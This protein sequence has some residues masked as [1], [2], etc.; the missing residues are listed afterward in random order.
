MSFPDSVLPPLAPDALSLTATALGE[1]PVGPSYSPAWF[2]SALDERKPTTFDGLVK[3][4]GGSSSSTLALAASLYKDAP[5]TAATVEGTLTLTEPTGLLG[6]LHVKGDLN[7]QASLVV[8]GTLTVDGVLT[9]GPETKLVVLGQ[10]RCRALN[11]SGWMT[12]LGGLAVEHALY[13]RFNDDSLE[14]PGTLT[15]G[16]ILSNDHLIYGKP[17]TAAHKP[18]ESG[19]WGPEVFDVRWAAHKAELSKVLADG[20]VSIVDEDPVVDVAK[21]MAARPPW[22]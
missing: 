12:L 3:A 20:I 1:L 18:S 6:D 22:K 7:L 8:V 11:T 19:P 13:G 5:R 21:L 10:V 17:K 14:V 15:A 9:D 16:I 4:F 2:Q